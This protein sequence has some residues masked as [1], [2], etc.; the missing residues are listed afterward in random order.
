MLHQNHVRR[1]FYIF[2]AASLL[3]LIIL[4]FLAI[5]RMPESDNTIAYS[6]PAANFVLHGKLALPQLGTQYHLNKYW[7][8]NSPL[9]A[10][11]QVP[12]FYL[13]GV[14]RT[15]D[16][17]GVSLAAIFSG[18]IVFFL[19]CRSAS[20]NSRLLIIPFAMFGLMGHRQVFA[21]L[22]NQRFLIIAIG[23]LALA[24]FPF[25]DRGRFQW[26][27]WLMAGGFTLLHPAFLPAQMIWFVFAVLGLMSNHS[28]G[29]LFNTIFQSEFLESRWVKL[30]SFAIGF[31]SSLC[32]Y[33]R[34]EA[35]LSQF[36]PHAVHGNQTG[37]LRANGPFA[38]I[39][40]THISPFYGIPS[41]MVSLGLVVMAWWLMVSWFLRKRTNITENSGFAGLASITVMA[42]S[43]LDMVKGFGYIIFYL[44][45]LA[46]ALIAEIRRQNDRKTALACLALMGFC[47]FVV[48]LKFDTNQICTLTT[49]EALDFIRD[50]TRPGDCIVIGPPFVFPSA[51]A[52]LGENRVIRYVVPQ[53]YWLSG[54]SDELFRREID[55]QCDVY[56]GAE[57]WYF[58][59]VGYHDSKSPDFPLFSNDQRERTTLQG[60]DLIIARKLESGV[61]LYEKKNQESFGI[62]NEGSA[63]LQ[64]KSH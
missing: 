24:F 40:G 53:P 62:G 16:L 36:L 44:V 29:P 63:L 39:L 58:H 35:F 11:G 25:R 52:Q 27:Q 45:A 8:L 54:F 14:S 49:S 12:F 9:M 23:V 42:V 48:S 15:A 28:D 38:G 19:L 22:Y 46:P 4:A 50:R 47:H 60:L 30:A 43:L 64:I 21:E 18:A 20:L 10:L 57:R 56:I 31:L 55:A 2:H 61:A 34:P 5:W 6:L 26:W 51:V 37:N 32:W 1:H 7:L 13:M 17:T 3:I 59:R 41:Q 33:A